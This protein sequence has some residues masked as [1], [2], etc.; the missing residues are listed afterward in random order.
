MVMEDTPEK[1]ADHLVLLETGWYI[2]MSIRYIK[3]DVIK[4]NAQRWLSSHYC[5]CM[6]NVHFT[7]LVD[8]ALCIYTIHCLMLYK[9]SGVLV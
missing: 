7:G 3:K 5:N 9:K 8:S 4:S 2:E 1:T 6:R